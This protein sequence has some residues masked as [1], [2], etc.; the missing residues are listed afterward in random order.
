MANRKLSTYQAKRDFKVT[1]E[2]SGDA[3]VAPSNRLR[4]VIQK[5]DATRLH[6]DL[7]LE[8]DGVFKSWAVT[9]G[10]SLDPHDK[11]LAV[12]VEDH[13]LDYG[14][15]EGTI[16]EGQYGGGTV[17]LWDRGYWTPEGMTAEEG[18]KKGDLKFVLDGEKLH[19][20]WVLVRMK[21]DKFGGKRTNWLLIKHDD[22]YAH[23][24]DHDAL[25]E[26]AKSVASGRDMDS[27]ADGKGRG[28]K[29]FVTV[30]ERAAPADAVWQSKPR[31]PAP[32]AKPERKAR[33]AKV[34]ALPGF[35]AP[36]L[37]SSVERPP[38]GSNWAH[39][40]KFDGYR[41]QLRVAG[42][43]AH[44]LTRKGLDWTTRFAGIAEAGA[45]LPDGIYDGEACALNAAGAPDF[46]ALQAALSDGDTGDLVYFVFDVLFAGGEDLRPLPLRE[47]KSRLKAVTD[48][49]SKQSAER[50][51]YVD[52]FTTAG[53][54]VL[55]SACRMGL[56]GIISKRLDAAYRSGRTETW[57]KAKCR[58]GHEVVIGGWSGDG[59]QVRSLLVGIQ[60]EGG[61][62]YLGRVGTGFGRDTV[63]RIMPKLKAVETGASPFSGANAPRKEA[64]LHWTKPELVAEIEY[65]GWTQAGILRQASFKGLRE[66]KPA[67]EVKV[68]EPA[69]AESTPLKAPS[70]KGAK[71]AG[72]TAAKDAVVMGVTISHPDKALW[73]DDGEGRPI[74]KLELARYY[75]LVGEWMMPHLKG[76][77]CSIIRAPDG[78]E[79]ELF[80]QRHGMKGTS[81]LLELVTVSGDRQP[82]LQIDRIEGLAAVAQTAAA[83][84]H[85]WNC[86]PFKPATPGRLVFDLDPAPDVGFD[87][88]IDAAREI[89]DRLEDLGLVSFCKT[90]GGKGLH[91]VAP[92]AP[93]D[94]LE[95]P[96]AKAFAQAVCRQLADEQ[97]DRYVLNMSKNQRSGRIFLDYLRNDRMSTAVAPLSPRARPGAPVSFPLTWSQ[98]KKG[99]DPK[100]YTLRTAPALLAETTAWR[101]Y[102]QSARP[103]RP[104][105]KRL[106]S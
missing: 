51:R 103:L 60:R 93:E 7:R 74:T 11:R 34:E 83:E 85:P 23:E 55:D 1:A 31:E 14:D 41:L 95:W 91:V 105:S 44:L 73:P 4:Y 65:G 101:D 5:H 37:A 49:L 26:G 3:P 63:A 106:T 76:R 42:G 97:P 45:D 27:I 33:A 43:K 68:V 69:P 39:E 24:G 58:A 16:P 75:E 52:H 10:P 78:I 98:V 50:I 36:Q 18:L 47:R 2:P 104:A 12:E 92:L 15:F 25:L 53:Q 38:P 21:G 62:V 46:P 13:P 77:P 87:A 29:P 100:R 20:S 8:A 64:G 82:Y 88:V 22:A 54:A 40:I 86:D 35:V 81:N 89:R 56:E 28:P 30:A 79:H 61:L 99:L 84:L 67:E 72:K 102:D 57:T 96:E 17:M 94:D 71:P 80:F 6:Y 66:D 48:L 70:S 59:A 90:T 19:G 32:Q 9:R